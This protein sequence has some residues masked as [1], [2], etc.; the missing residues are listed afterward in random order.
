MKKYRGWSSFSMFRSDC[1]QAAQGDVLVTP[2][3]AAAILGYSKVSIRRILD[4]EDIQ[5]WAWYEADQFHASEVLV[6]VRSL[7]RFGLKKGRLGD[8]ED[9]APL[10]AVLDRASYEQLRQAVRG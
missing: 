7:V 10:R 3:V 1:A 5:S 2:P 8:Y 9:E 6:S 4:Q